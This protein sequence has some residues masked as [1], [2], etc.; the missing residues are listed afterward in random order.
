MKNEDLFSAF[1]QLDERLI[2]KSEKTAAGASVRS[3]LIA[4][5]CTCAALLLVFA[6]VKLIKN[7]KNVLPVGQEAAAPEQ[8]AIAPAAETSMPA[9]SVERQFIAGWGFEKAMDISPVIFEGVCV[10]SAVR[11][12]P[13]SI[14][15]TVFPATLECVFRVEKVW[16]GELKEGSEV[17]IRAYNDMEIRKGLRHLLFAEPY[18][19]VFGGIERY[20]VPNTVCREGMN[21]A[22]FGDSFFEYE[23]LDYP[24]LAELLEAKLPEHPYSGNNTVTGEYCISE[25]LEEIA[26]YAELIVRVRAEEVVDEL[27]SDR[28]MYRCTVLERIKGDSDGKIYVI[29][30]E[31][32]MVP[33]GEYVLLV[34]KPDA[35]TVSYTVCSLKSV[36]PADGAEAAFVLGF[37]K[38]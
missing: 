30:F 12:E 33:G 11:T 13:G 7:G 38:Q 4:C 35:G 27:V 3:V 14:A 10:S 29:A 32:C 5:A 25:D 23:E 8:S 20:Y 2:L 9:I 17:I 21:G 36:L 37:F 34:S 28:D 1:S 15:G 16:R 24:G 6:G 31:D 19:S 22:S 18:A 26:A